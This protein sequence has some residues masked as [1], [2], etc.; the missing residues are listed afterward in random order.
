MPTFQT[1]YTYPLQKQTDEFNYTL[2]PR[3]TL[4]LA[5]LIQKMYIKNNAK[6]NYDNIYDINRLG[7][8][9][10]NEGRNISNIW[11]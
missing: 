10:I 4:N 2:T 5:H 7:L 9:E 1:N 6:I 11:L 8:D 3:F